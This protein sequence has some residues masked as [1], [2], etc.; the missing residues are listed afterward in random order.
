MAVSGVVEEEYIH[1]HCNCQ[2]INEIKF[3]IVI[4]RILL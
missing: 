4:V 2:T 3:K 1:L